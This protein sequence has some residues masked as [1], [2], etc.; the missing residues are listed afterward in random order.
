M[1]NFNQKQDRR[2]FNK[3]LFMAG[4]GAVI[5]PNSFLELNAIRKSKMKLG[6]VTY[7][8]GKDWD[9]D[10]L[11]KNCED[12]KLG[13]VELRVE[14]AHNV[15]TGLTMPERKE[16]K[17]KFEGSKVECLG[18][19]TNQDYHHTDQSVLRESIEKTKEFI[20]LSH[21]IGATGVKVKPNT[22]PEGVSKEKTI[23][24]I[25]KSLNEVAAFGA[26]Y[27]QQIRVEVHGRKTQRLP[28]MKAIFDVADHPNAT[29][30]WNCN[31]EDLMD[32]GL[33]E[34]FNLVKGRFGDTVHVRELNVGEYPYQDLMN[35]FVEMDYNGWILLECRTDPADRV[36]AMKEQHKIFKKMLKG[37]Y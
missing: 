16:V 13:G 33:K 26:E 5:T 30:C 31:D 27:G 4:L 19:G 36:V 17:M 21:D 12:A 6:L 15:H 7:L 32:G 25:G 10:T 22:L 23:E 8:W 2:N 11:I 3:S 20:K 28:V 14:H 1:R 18:M 37:K 34:N 35:L 29:V 9:L 24:Q